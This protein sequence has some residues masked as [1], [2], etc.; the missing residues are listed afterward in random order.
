MGSVTLKQWKWEECSERHGEGRREPGCIRQGKGASRS[1]GYL[2]CQR[3]KKVNAFH[4]KCLLHSTPR[5]VLGNGFGRMKTTTYLEVL[6]IRSL[7]L[8][9]RYLPWS[10][11]GRI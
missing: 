5:T 6:T 11:G 1:R 7:A 3:L 10:G 2:L 8:L 4:S 9:G